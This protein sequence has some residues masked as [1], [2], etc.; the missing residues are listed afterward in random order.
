MTEGAPEDF[1]AKIGARGLQ[2]A[3]RAAEAHGR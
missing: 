2:G 3:D 1:K